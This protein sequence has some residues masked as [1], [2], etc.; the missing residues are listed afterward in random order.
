MIA[1]FA[2]LISRT[3]FYFRF[4]RALFTCAQKSS[5]HTARM[6]SAAVL[7]DLESLDRD[8]LKALI[9]TQHGQLLSHH[10][11]LRSNKN[12][13]ESLQLLI[14]K[15]RRTQFGRKSEKLDRQIAQLELKLEE[16]Q[17][18]QAEHGREAE[19][20]L[21]PAAS[22][23]LHTSDRPAR[24]PLPKHLPRETRKDMPK[25]EACPDCGGK[26]REL[27]EDVSEVLEYVPTPLKI[28]PKRR[29]KTASAG[30]RHNQQE[31]GPTLGN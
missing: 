23:G 11:Q 31:E 15:L 8:A 28:L 27:G 12:E 25:Q 29:P 19:S 10:E 3:Y 4:V 6:T 2:R 20:P 17:A 1:F 18:Q 30:C 24:R 9:V 21:P 13:I 14:A 16:L 7:S 22:S 5:W 26:V